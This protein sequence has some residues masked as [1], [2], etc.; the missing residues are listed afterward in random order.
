[1]NP[2]PFLDLTR[3]GNLVKAEIVAALSRVVDSGCFVLGPE[4]D[5]FER[6]LA[7]YSQA[8]HAIACASG[9]EALLMA[10]MALN[11]QPGDE[12]IVPSFTFFATASAVVR[13]GATPVFADIQSETFNID[14]EDVARKI[15]PK[16]RAI[17]AVHLFGQAA[18]MEALCELADKHHVTL[19][20]DVAQAIGAEASFHG[21]NQRVG[22][23]G[24]IGCFSFYPT[25]NLGT[26]GDGGALTT[27]DDE[28]ADKLRLI[29]VH[30]MRPRYYHKLVGINGRLDA[31]QGAVLNVKFPHLDDYTAERQKIAG[32]YAAL[33][34]EVELTD[35]QIQLPKAPAEG[36]H[37]WN[38]FCVLI[39]QGRRDAL[40]AFLAER[41]I[42]SEI[43]YP[44]GLHEQ[45]CF[46]SLGCRLG[47]LPVT[48][49][50]SREILALP[51]FPGLT[52]EE[53]RSVVEGI[54]AF[55]QA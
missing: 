47:D 19:I 16:T 50:V 24:K 39:R 3:S 34:A 11:I 22:S 2:V 33:F 42:G 28:L 18:D 51:I 35:E 7:E 45:E 25:K 12:V 6:T 27:C 5:R 23:M 53:Q 41:K 4:I 48:E 1:M 36:R 32:Q 37:V 20:E 17:I 29:R 49:L 9:S 15:T 14:P 43:Y 38:Q 21:R 44:L 46:Q 54:Q 31:F 40:R 52:L 26:M 55:F 10:L 13:L 8:S 30:G